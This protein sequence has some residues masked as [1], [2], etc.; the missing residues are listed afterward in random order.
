MKVDTAAKIAGRIKVSCFSRRI[1]DMMPIPAARRMYLSCCPAKRYAIVMP[2]I[3]PT[4]PS[5]SFLTLRPP[6]QMI[7][8]AIS[9]IVP[10]LSIAGAGSCVFRFSMFCIICII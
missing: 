8:P 6:S 5:I 1:P 2:V 10:M 7:R 4:I 3:I 9:V